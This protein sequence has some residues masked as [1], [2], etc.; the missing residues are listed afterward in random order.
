MKSNN[1]VKNPN[2]TKKRNP[3]QVEKNAKSKSL[4]K[5]SYEE[6]KKLKSIVESYKKDSSKNVIKGS[7]TLIN[8]NEVSSNFNNKNGRQCYLRYRSINKPYKKGKWTNNETKQMH[9]LVDFHGKNWSKIS[10][11]MQTRSEK[12]IRDH[13]I[14]FTLI[15]DNIGKF[16]NEEVYQL[17]DLYKKHGNKFSL[18]SKQMPGRSTEEIKFYYNLHIK[19]NLGQSNTIKKNNLINNYDERINIEQN[20]YNNN[21]NNN[22]NINNNINQ[23]EKEKTQTKLSHGSVFSKSKNESSSNHTIQPFNTDNDEVFSKKE[24]SKL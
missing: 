5:W 23:I 7:K 17:K 24:E 11:I 19:N 12:Q 6:D 13:Y 1:V 9:E 18:I 22:N 15:K 14:Y 4:S 8:W 3:F 16:T 20:N 10:K 2:K 21:N